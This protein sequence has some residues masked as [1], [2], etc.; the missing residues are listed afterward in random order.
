[1]LQQNCILI[2]IYFMKKLLFVS[3]L[4]S[5]F[6]C[7]RMGDPKE[8]GSLIKPSAELMNS[9]KNSIEDNSSSFIEL[10]DYPIN[11]ISKEN[12]NGDFYLTTKGEKKELAFEKSNDSDNQKFYL[13]FVESGGGNI[14]ILTYINGEKYVLVAGHR[15]NDP[16][17]KVIFPTKVT[18]G[19]TF[20]KGYF[21]KFLSG[22]TVHPESYILR[23]TGIRYSENGFT[24]YGV[25][26]NDNFSKVFINKYLNQGKQEF[27]IR[28]VDDFEI[29]SVQFDDTNTANVIQ[30]P[31][32]V[33][34]WFYSNNTSVQQSMSTAF[35][36]RASVTSNWSKTTGGSIN[37]NTTVKTGIPFIAEGK[38]STTLSTNYSATYGK[39][40][41]ME[42]T[43]TYNFPIVVA[44]RTS[45]TATA[46]VGRSLINLKYTAKLKGKKTGKLITLN[47]TWS[48]VSCNNIKVTLEQRDLNNNIIAKKE[49]NEIPKTLY[50]P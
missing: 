48:G 28:P 24:D 42:D 45:I 3:I 5:I 27:E 50:K 46:I 41:T 12:I 26:G 32:F 10:K 43:Q 40:E 21:W 37:V 29:V 49:L 47:G 1:M 9:K 35:S 6:S 20:V 7:S 38:V 31:D 13:D 8:S 23:N 30:Q 25:L 33:T 19:M 44:P 14:S 18:P 17:F 2:L 16:N 36:Q 15:K 11:I 39:N 22:S 34:K 4:A